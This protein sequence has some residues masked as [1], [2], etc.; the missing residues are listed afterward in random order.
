MCCGDEEKVCF[1]VSAN[2]G[3]EKERDRMDV[4]KLEEEKRDGESSRG[5]LYLNGLDGC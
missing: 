1:L 3:S 2:E 5:A 4:D